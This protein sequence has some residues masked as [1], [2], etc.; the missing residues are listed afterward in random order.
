MKRIREF[1]KLSEDHHHGLVLARRAR[2]AGAGTEGFSVPHVWEEVE[3]KFQYEFEPHF[4]IEEKYL[5]PPLEAIGEIKLINRLNDDHK[6]LRQRISDQSVR[7]PLALKQF[8]EI[9]EKH[10]R[11]EE[12]ELF[13]IAQKRLSFDALQSLER[14]CQ[15]SPKY[16]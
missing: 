6:I 14:A 10:I 5:V 9:L 7:T 8:G 15:K 3:E 13:E 2:L 11:F 4:I 1:R 12:R 16:G